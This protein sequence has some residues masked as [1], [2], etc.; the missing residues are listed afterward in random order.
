MFFEESA[1]LVRFYAKQPAI[2]KDFS[3]PLALMR[4]GGDVKLK[5]KTWFLGP[6]GKDVVLTFPQAWDWGLIW[7]KTRENIC[8]ILTL[9]K[10]RVWVKLVPSTEFL[11]EIWPLVENEN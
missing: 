3:L 7:D 1:L 5:G 8:F 2:K 10:A 6:L 9:E 11:L 4:F